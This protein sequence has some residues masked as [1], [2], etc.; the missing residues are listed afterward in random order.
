M[1][2]RVNENESISDPAEIANKFNEY[3]VNVGPNLASKIPD[4]TV[5]FTSY[6][7]NSNIYSVFLDPVTEKEVENQLNKLKYGKSCG[8]DEM[9]PKVMRKISKHILKPLTHIYN[10]SFLTGIIPTE[11]KIAVVTPIF[12]A[13]DKELFSN[14]RPMSVLPC[15]S[16]ILEKLM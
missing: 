13:N 1:H 6:L 14:Y 12:K 7:T 5:Q 15:F 16:K 3:F 8:Y 9:S 4:N 2:S 10:Q 11:L